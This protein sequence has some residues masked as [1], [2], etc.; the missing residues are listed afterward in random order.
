VN[1]SL[2]PAELAEV[3]L[4]LQRACGIVFSDRHGPPIRS[5]FAQAAS[6]LGIDPRALLERVRT[7][8]PDALRALVEGS[9]VGETYFARHPEQF[10][11]L[12]VV[13]RG[14]PRD[15]PFRVWCAGCAS[16]E[17]AYTMAALLLEEGRRTPGSILATDVSQ[18]A[19]EAARRGRYG[20]WSLRGL[21][22]PSRDRWLRPED[23][24][25]SVTP[26]LR[27]LVVFR[28]H[29]LVTDPPPSHGFDVVFCRNVLIYFDRP[30]VDGVVRRLFDA[31]LP[32]GIVAFAPAE[33]IFA[34]PLGF[35]RMEHLGGA[36]WRKSR[37]RKRAR[38]GPPAEPGRP[39]ARSRP[40]PPPPAPAAPIAAARDEATRE[41][42]REPLLEEARRA[43]SEGR[44]LEAEREAAR[45]GEEH[46]RPEPFL[47]AAA[48]AEA[49]GDVPA[50][51]AWLGRALFLD[52]GHVVARAT[53]VPLLERT[54]N[55]KE[56]ARAR[57]QAL[58]ALDSVP[59]DRLMPGIEPVA[60][61]AL[62]AALA[63]PPRPEVHW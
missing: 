2:R 35:E 53:L 31:V 61:G 42:E 40:P 19:I 29:N 59:D 14:E 38:R 18:A 55:H 28:R 46:L 22:A 48:A 1:V 17:E 6:A 26:E 34:E 8:D 62:R 58:D 5:G 54:G 4:A 3:A 39:A 56:A 20:P 12:R 47:F 51:V 49:R 10:E 13:M 45:V 60:A 41:P 21:A 57:R 23:G 11:A 7:G 33:N 52:P 24:E 16:G 30:T 36:L 25:W 32:G 63:A 43:A 50:A 9:V 44:W 37:T 27:D 15:R